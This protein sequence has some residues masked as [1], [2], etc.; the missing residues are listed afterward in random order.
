MC[1]FLGIATLLSRQNDARDRRPRT[2][3]ARSRCGQRLLL[4]AR[5]LGLGTVLGPAAG[6]PVDSAGA[7]RPRRDGVADTRQVFHATTADQHDGVFLEVMAFPGDVTRHFHAVG[8]PHTGDL[9]ERRVRFLWRRRVD[10][11]ADPT[12]LRSALECGCTGLLENPGSA[13]ADQLVQRWQNH[14]S[15]AAGSR[16]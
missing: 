1:F 14:S 6:A 10:T 11:G 7:Q 12:L 2:A 15:T 4:A 13:L 3:G 16:P 8:E 9:A 5:L